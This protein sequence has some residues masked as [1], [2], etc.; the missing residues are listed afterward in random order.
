MLPLTKKELQSHENAKACYICGKY[1]IKKFFRDINY[2]KVRDH[3][4]YTG[5]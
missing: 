5:K 3:S 1:F 2:Q 4:Y